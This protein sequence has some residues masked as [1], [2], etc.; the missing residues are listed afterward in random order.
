M[1]AVMG[2]RALGVLLQEGCQIG[3]VG[4]GAAV[5]VFGGSL[6]VHELEFNYCLLEYV[7]LYA[8]TVH[9]TSS[10]RMNSLPSK[11]ITQTPQHTP[12]IGQHR[13]SIIEEAHKEEWDILLP[14]QTAERVQ[15]WNG[16]EIRIS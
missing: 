5:S 6:E 14:W 7:N 11:P 13:I 2:R 8:V 12:S 9:L 1:P 4:T 10:Q 16:E 15:V 3:V